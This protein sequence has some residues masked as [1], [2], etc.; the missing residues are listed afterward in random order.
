MF[1][2]QFYSFVKYNQSRLLNYL[3]YD[4]YPPD[5]LSKCEENGLI[6]EQAYIILKKN[7]T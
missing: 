3:Q 7:K 1:K 5:A 2:E 6:A 4:N